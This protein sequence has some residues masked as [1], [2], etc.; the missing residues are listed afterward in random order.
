MHMYICICSY[1]YMYAHTHTHI[2]IS[3]IYI[4]TYIYI[5]IYST[6]PP[7]HHHHVGAQRLPIVRDPRHRRHGRLRHGHRQARHP[8]GLPLRRAEDGRRV[9]SARRPRGP[10]WRARRVRANRQRQR[11]RA[12]PVRLLLRSARQKLSD[13]HHDVDGGAA[14]LRGGH[15]DVPPRAAAEILWGGALVRAVRRYVRQLPERKG[16]RGGHD[17]RL[18]EGG[19]RGA[20]RHTAGGFL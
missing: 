4:H 8:Q 3:H 11:L 7:P 10:R 1:I 16:A 5:H 18:W 14:R 19:A 12:L 17:A 9:L 6:P 20:T 2:Y 13:G 15:A